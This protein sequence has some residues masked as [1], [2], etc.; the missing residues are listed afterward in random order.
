MNILKRYK[1]LHDYTIQ[2]STVMA[3][4]EKENNAV[5]HY[6]SHMKD[7]LEKIVAGTREVLHLIES[8]QVNISKRMRGKKDSREIE[9]KDT[10]SLLERIVFV[11]SETFAITTEGKNKIMH[12]DID[13]SG[14]F[15]SVCVLDATSTI[16]PSYTFHQRNSDDIQFME[17]I[18]VRNYS[19]V[20]IN[21]CHNR[22]L[23]QSKIAIYTTPKKNKTLNT[24]V[25]QYLT[26]I[27]GIL[28]PDDRLLVCTYKI[29]VPL[30]K[31]LCPFDNVK[32]IHWGSSDARGSNEFKDFN[33]A[34]AIGFFRRPQHVY[35]G[36]VLA[37]KDYKFYVPTNGSVSRDA[38]QLK[39][40]L[41]VDD[42]VQFFN[43]VRCRVSIDE[44]GNCEQAELYL[45]TGGNESVKLLMK[46]LIEQE[47][48]NITSSEWTVKADA[49]LVAARNKNKL[50]KLAE[51]AVEWLLTVSYEY[52][53]V[54]QKHLQEYFG[55]SPSAMKRLKQE[56]HFQN[57]CV[58]ED[59][60]EIKDGR[61]FMFHLPKNS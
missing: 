15:G 59:I 47:M 39:N 11:F 4:M 24:V 53:V 17:R 40:H 6:E 54:S 5:V 34:M 13:L 33:R 3:T 41:S 48:P 45:F 51:E 44:E 7:M 12:R 23:P 58:E 21:V 60:V 36:A 25:K 57:L 28:D 26:A 61:S 29:L 19:N 32:F 43:R 8:R 49:E 30:F 10:I 52:D 42:M 18:D 50:Y 20:N 1:S 46:E 35:N 55:I 14:A 2:L 22:N 27:E 38:I 16:N 9:L 56:P 37:I 31:H